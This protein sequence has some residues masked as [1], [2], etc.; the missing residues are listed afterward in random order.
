MSSVITQTQ[1]L[2]SYSPFLYPDFAQHNPRLQL[3]TRNVSFDI[4]RNQLLL[5]PESLLIS[6]FPR[7]LM[8]D[9]ALQE[10]GNAVPP[11]ETADFDPEL[12]SHILDT[13]INAYE[14]ASQ[15]P[16]LLPMPPPGFPGRCGIIFLRED[17]EYY[18][19]EDDSPYTVRKSIHLDFEGKRAAKRRIG[20]LLLQKKRIFDGLIETG[21][22][23]ENSTEAHLV[24]MLCYCGF[25]TNQEWQYRMQEQSRTCITS[26]SIV[27]L[28]F[29]A[30]EGDENDPSYVPVYHKL[31]LFWRKPA[32]KCWWTSKL[33][34]EVK[35][36]PCKSWVRRVWTLELSVF[37]E[38]GTKEPMHLQQD[39]MESESNSSFETPSSQSLTSLSTEMQ[40][41]S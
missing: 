23:S 41:Q 9:F 18:V 10:S 35:G 13:Y 34:T 19:L 11:L 12:L 7:G 14:K 20:N 22:E 39:P 27:N 4:T 3:H 38:P 32:R 37:G 26:V 29:S 40:E 1:E 17:I 21:A 31:L 24:R 28:D 5:M 6:L 2:S 30:D 36:V 8:L 33:R 16:E 15:H 25:T